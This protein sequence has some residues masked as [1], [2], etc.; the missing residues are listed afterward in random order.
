MPSTVA[1]TQGRLDIY[2]SGNF[3][4]GVDALVR[5][6]QPLLDVPSAREGYALIAG[7]FRDAED[8]GPT[9]VR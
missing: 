5:A 4:G 3:P 1:E 6:T 7:K 2:N 8:F 9:S